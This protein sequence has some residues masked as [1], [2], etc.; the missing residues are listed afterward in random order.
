MRLSH[1]SSL[2]LLLSAVSGCSCSDP[3]V[4]DD[5]GP[6]DAR[7]I[8]GDGPGS[9]GRVSMRCGNSVIE[10]TEECDDGNGVAD[11]GCSPTCTLDC[12]D[13]M[14]S[15]AEIC[16]VDI[17]AGQTGACP[18]DCDDDDACTTDALD[19]SDCSAQCSHGAITMATDGDGCCPPGEDATTDM[20]CAAMCGNGIVESGETCDTAIAAGNRGAC[21]ATCDDG[22]SCTTDTASGAACTAACANVEITAAA[23]DDGCCPTGATAATDNDCT[24]C[25][26]GV[27]TAPETCDT[28]IAAG[29]GR[30]PTMCND[31]MA[32]TADSLI[33]GGTCM[34]ACS[35]TPIAAGPMDMCCP[36][37]ATIGTDP[38]CPRRC[39]DGV[40]TAP[41]TCDDGN[42]MG[43]D[44]CSATCTTEATP[45]AFRFTD[46]DLRDPH[47]YGRI[48]FCV[49]ATN[50]AFGM[51]GVN[52]LL[53]NNIQRDGDMDGDLDLSMAHV[54][55]PLVQTA[56]SSTP[57][58]LAF[59]DCTAPMSSTMCTLAAG[60]TRLSGSAMN[61][62]MGA[63]C[64]PTIAGTTRGA[65]TPAIVQPTAPA[66]GTC[67]VAMAG[68]ITFDLG[69]IPIT[70]QD[71]HI[72]GEW[73][74][75]P[76]TEIRDGLLRGFL[77]EADANRTIIPDGTT[78]QTAIDCQPIASLLPGG[79]PPMRTAADPPP[80][81]GCADG[82]GAETPMNPPAN[83]AGHSDL[84]TGPG[85][86]RGWY[87]YLNFTAARVP[88]TAL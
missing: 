13:G 49:D 61:S 20:D 50:T 11:D 24:G 85:G 5:G 60:A 10:G 45:T 40:T 54:F 9:D 38:D 44:G 30:C 86:A 35:N 12:G 87:F 22:I 69:G 17:A 84:D 56:G 83:C 70:L 15:G 2:A 37:G 66:G 25:G 76:A 31:M 16:D 62:G 26:D 72:G 79:D 8:P 6:V 42:T 77:S 14:V 1:L 65:Y 39:G 63:V 74:G 28:G 58:Y 52:P 55:E 46:L 82:A 81:M 48:V 71:V 19:G 36:T 34:A 23:D 43:G 78:G 18:T 64:L 27:V 75:S 88:Y 68:T 57:S 53:Q 33:A 32:C 4:L 51:D 21:P 80:P 73:F 29:E 7:A 41:E 3:P 67:Y 47:I 59:P